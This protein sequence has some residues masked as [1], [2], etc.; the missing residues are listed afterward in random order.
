MMVRPEKKVRAE[1]QPE[2][3]SRSSSRIIGRKASTTGTHCR[4]LR[5]RLI[6]MPIRNTTTSAS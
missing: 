6:R 4:T 3:G 5:H 1:R 2:E